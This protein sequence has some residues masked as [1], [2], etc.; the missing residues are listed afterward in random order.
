MS[1]VVGPRSV[2]VFLDTC[3]SGDSRG[4]V[5]RLIAA[6]PLGIKVKEQAAS[7]GFTVF[8]AAGGDQ[9]C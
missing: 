5:E 9:N 6:R 2:T 3:Y 4:G 1:L 8:T 7:D